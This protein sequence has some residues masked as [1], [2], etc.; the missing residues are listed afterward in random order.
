MKRALALPLCALVGTGCSLRSGAADKA[1]GGG[2]PVTLRLAFTDQSDVAPGRAAEYFARRVRELSGGRLRVKILWQA[3]GYRSPRWELQI[4]D[5]ART[6]HADLV[7]APSRA[8]AQA[9]ASRLNA[10]TA[11]FLLTTDA[12]VRRVVDGPL[13]RELIGAMPGAVGLAMVPGGLRHPFSFG[14]PLLRRADYVGA[15]VRAPYSDIVYAAWRNLGSHPVDLPGEQLAKATAAHRVAVA[16]SGYEFAPGLTQNT[17]ATGNVTPFA[18]IDV[19]AAATGTFAAMGARNQEILRRAAGDMT[20]NALRTA[21]TD[22][23]L[24]Q[25]FCARGGRVLPAP[26]TEVRTMMA[27]AAPVTQHLEQDPRTRQAIETIRSWSGPLEGEPVTR[28]G[29]AIHA[30]RPAPAREPSSIHVLDGVYRL[31]WSQP[32]MIRAGMTAEFAGHESGVQTLTLRGGRYVW[33]QENGK[34]PPDCSGPYRVRGHTFWIDMNVPTCSGVYDMSWS[35]KGDELWL[36]N[37]DA[38]RNDAIWWGTKP[39]RRIAR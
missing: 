29:K 27:A 37:P 5:M 25:A 16:D 4:V 33:H 28:C 18:R 26:A 23:Q 30:L 22:E 32:E 17:T 13:T 34:N 15:S 35:L 7:M 24:A 31:T 10:L 9:G 36:S 8:W 14:Q 3:A 20:R 11:P 38:P 6:G 12:V 19:L 1:G 2:R 21:R 39:W